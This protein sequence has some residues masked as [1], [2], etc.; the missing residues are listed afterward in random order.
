MPIPVVICVGHDKDKLKHV[1]NLVHLSG[2]DIRFAIL[3][4]YNGPDKLDGAI[5]VKN[6][7]WD[8]GMY[9]TGFASAKRE[10]IEFFFFLND[11]VQFIHRDWLAYAKIKIAEGYEII[12]QANLL[13]WIDPD[14]ICKRPS[15]RVRERLRDGTYRKVRFIR[16]HAFACTWTYFDR[17]WRYTLGINKGIIGKG[18]KGRLT[19]NVFEKSTILKAES[20]ALFPHPSWIYDSNTK[21]Y[22]NN[23]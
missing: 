6:E 17:I 3:V 21:P 12:G 13:S 22:V 11:D 9:H 16:T 8:I 10:D 7:G 15:K 18:E 19:A 14:K 1:V 5:C 2:T 4:I 20:Y 23:V